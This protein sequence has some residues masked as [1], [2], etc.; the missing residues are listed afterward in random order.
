MHSVH[1]HRPAEAVSPGLPPSYDPRC[2]TEEDGGALIRVI[3]SLRD[4]MPSLPKMCPRW[5]STVFTLT[6]NSAAACRLDRP[7]ATRRATDC[8]A[9]V[10]PTKAGAVCGPA[11]ALGAICRRCA[12]GVRVVRGTRRAGRARGIPPRRRSGWRRFRPSGF[13][14]PHR[15]DRWPQAGCRPAHG[16]ARRWC[17][18]A[19]RAGPPA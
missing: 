11:G 2:L 5:N 8:S 1:G 17:A 3:S 4:R 9:G 10:R 15:A 14:R 18:A 12:A 19:P 7:S 13:P 16:R 6:Y